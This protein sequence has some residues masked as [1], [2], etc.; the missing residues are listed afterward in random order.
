MRS[1]PR[2]NSLK[3]R[4]ASGAPTTPLRCVDG[5]RTTIAPVLARATPSPPGGVFPRKLSPAP[6]RKPIAGIAHRALGTNDHGVA[7]SQ[8]VGS[9]RAHE[10]RLEVDAHGRRKTSPGCER[11]G[12]SHRAPSDSKTNTTVTRPRLVTVKRRKAPS[13]EGAFLVL[14]VL[15]A[16]KGVRRCPTLPQG[17]PCSTIGAESLSFRVRNVTG[18]FPLAMAAETFTT[19]QQQL[20]VKSVSDHAPTTTPKGDSRRLSVHLFPT[21]FREPHSGREQSFPHLY[22]EGVLSSYRLISTGQLHG[23]LVPTSTSG[24]STQ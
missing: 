23:S 3:W 20:M 15:F 2:A 9:G 4:R 5:R 18:R 16:L 13:E 10:R 21:V 24:L 6:G 17:P 14:L 22:R 8:L 12:N 19:H 11:W 7:P 1:L